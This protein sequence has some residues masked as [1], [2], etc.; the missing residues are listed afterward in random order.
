MK[1]THTIFFDDSKDMGEI[2]SNSI[3][4]LITSPPY[5][6]IEMWDELFSSQDDRIGL[7][8]KNGKGK[9]AY[10]LMH[11]SLSEVWEECVRVVKESGIICINIGDATRKIGKTFQLFPNHVKVSQFFQDNGSIP[12]PM[13]LWRK[14]TNSP[15]KFMGSG[16]LPSNAYVTLEH[17]YILLFRNGLENR[18]FSPNS[19]TRYNSAF[20]W[21]E[22]NRWFSDI[23][24]DMR[25]VSQTLQNNGDLRERSAAF[26]IELP[27]RLIN[28]FSVYGDT[29]LDPFWGTGTTTLA[30][31]ILAR[32]SIGFELDSEFIRIFEEN[33][34]KI[35]MINE[36]FNK[37]RIK[38]HI[39][40]VENYSKRN[41]IKYTSINY[42]FP[43]ITSQEQNI[44]FYSIQETTSDEHNYS[45]IHKPYELEDME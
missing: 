31:M 12:L 20:F 10:D 16:M 42:R 34:K 19:E 44:I 13:I 7:A 29:V 14:P 3:D 33:I 15:T 43:V 37:K 17:E 2:K 30:A 26:P 11:E 38:T 8:L 24:K 39:R 22:R 1:T 32:N 18:K 45:L 23:W 41:Q 28:M 4:L 25:G 35:K 27:Y 5:P 36:T 9:L 6:M 21:E 40:F